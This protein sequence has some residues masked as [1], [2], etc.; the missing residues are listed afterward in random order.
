MNLVR[1][2]P[3][4]PERRGWLN[5]FFTDS[6]FEPFL[7]EGEELATESFVPAVDIREEEEKYILEAELPG[8]KK[9]DVH[10]E[11]KDGVLTFSGERKSE[12][13][14]KTDKYTRVERSHGTFKR[15]FSLPE[16]VEE[17]KIEAAYKDGVLTMTLPKGEK[18][19][20][21]QIDVKVH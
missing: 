11:V 16:H 20:P 18:A 7:R 5:R 1:Y 12:H 15:T 17:E 3:W 19:K 2:D 6:L 21:K 8:M 9:E 4:W 10:I 14:E 13:E